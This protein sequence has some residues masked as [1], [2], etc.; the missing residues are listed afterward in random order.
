MSLGGGTWLFQNKVL[1]GAYINFKSK[2]RP[3]ATFA[4]R[5]YAAIPL[6]LDWGVDDAVFTVDAAEFLKDTKLYFGYDYTHDKIKPLRD[7]FVKL[8]TGHFYRANGGG[9]KADSD[10]GTAKYSGIR[11]NDLKMVVSANVDAA[12]SYDIV[13]YLDTMVVDRQTVSDMAD[14]KD[15]D[16]II[17]K[18]EW[19]LAATAGTPLIGGTNGT[20]TGDSYQ[21]F[22][23]LI[24]QKYFNILLCPS[25]ESTIKQL[26]VTYT[27]RMRDDVGIKFQLVGH[28]ID[29]ADYE[30]VISVYNDVTDEGASPAEGIYWVAGA[31]ASCAIGFSGGSTYISLTNMT[32]DGEYTINTNLR[33][34]EIEKQRGLGQ[35]VFHEAGKRVNGEY[36]QTVRVL[37]DINTFTSFTVEKNNDF[38]N[39][40]VIRTL[41]QIAID[42][43]TLFN[44]SFL[45]KVQN[46]EVGRASLKS[47]IIF[48]HRELERV[49]AIQNFNGDDVIVEKGQD[50]GNVL[51][52]DPVEP[53]GVMT[54]LY[55]QVVVA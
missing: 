10:I 13:T 32:Y 37:E 20:V 40:Q 26:F 30:G 2:D 33:Q 52:T 53:T 41:D 17:F 11:G 29:N 18:K 31:E 45:G 15:S 14:I 35:F 50:K 19:T 34:S 55:M 5:G 6:E 12:G 22:L 43:A 8:Q 9:V 44:E 39:N 21:T 47:N 25:T 48:H 23:D 51:V 4:D 16:Y 24:E 49:R 7:L 54:R 38:S 46:D 36:V 3:I 27:K 28:Q 42:I 1:P